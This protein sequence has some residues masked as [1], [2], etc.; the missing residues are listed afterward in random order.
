MIFCSCTTGGMASRTLPCVLGLSVG[1]SL[2]AAC[3]GDDGPPLATE[4]QPAIEMYA[5]AARAGYGASMTTAMQLDTAIDA[6]IANPSQQSL[7]AARGAWIAARQPYR[8]TEGMRFY[9]G[10]IDDPAD[11]REP[12]INAWPMDEAYVD[13]VVGNP[14]AGIINDTAG[15]PVIDEASLR[16]ANFVGGESNVSTG[17]HAIEFLLWGQDQ[18]TTGPGARPYTD[19]VDGGTAANQD[20]RRAYLGVVSDMLVADLAH[21]AGRWGAQGDYTAVFTGAP[22]ESVT[23][24]LTGIGTLS[25]SELSG[26]RMLTAYENKDQED[27][28]SCFSDTTLDDLKGNLASIQL[29]WDAGLDDLV[30]T[31]DGDLAARMTMQLATARTALMAIPGPFDQA[32][33]GDDSSPGRTSVL[34][35]IRAI[36]DVGDTVVDIAGALDVPVSTEL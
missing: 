28:H 27:E 15:F 24:I 22:V 26:E 20:R 36:Q 33:L 30:T 13:Y 25:A 11:E 12:G 8:N 21:V 29:I 7:D 5:A 10:P 1:L 9:G 14:N 19:F 32:I 3:G 31:Y 23:R 6:F 4:A 2:V 18:S 17:Y 16:A 34:A 35:A